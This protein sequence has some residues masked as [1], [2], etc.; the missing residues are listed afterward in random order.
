VDH[1]VAAAVEHHVGGLQVA[2]Q[3]SLC[4]SRGEACAQLACDFDGLV[5][6]Q[7][8]NA[9]QERSEVFAIDILHRKIKLAVDFAEIVDAADIGVR[10]LARDANFI[11]K[12]GADGRI[13]RGNFR[14]KLERDFLAQR[15][16]VSAIDLAHTAAA[17][18]RD[19]S[20][21]IGEQRTGQE[22]AL[23]Q[24]SGG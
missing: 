20:I 6:G 19:N 4:M 5:G 14:Q 13:V 17:K 2:V 7:A 24:R 3:N 16:V 15:E 18:Q 12:T 10:D 11:V 8:A 1:H 23:R 9:P 21:A 22:A